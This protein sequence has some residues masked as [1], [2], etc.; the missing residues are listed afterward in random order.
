MNFPM[1][2]RNNSACSRWKVRS[3]PLVEGDKFVPHVMMSV[4]VSVD[5]RQKETAALR[6]KIN[7]NHYTNDL[8]PKCQNQDCYNLQW[9]SFVVQKILRMHTWPRW[10]NTPIS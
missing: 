7:D 2:N 4:E 6:A 3:H 1:V 5:L 8:L 9:S 10:R